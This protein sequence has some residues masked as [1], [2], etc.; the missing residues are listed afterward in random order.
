MDKFSPRLFAEFCNRVG[1]NRINAGRVAPLYLFA[2]VLHGGRV[3]MSCCDAHP[4]CTGILDSGLEAHR[5]LRDAIGLL[6]DLLTVADLEM[7]FL[8]SYGDEPF[9]SQVLY[10]NVPVFH[11]SGSESYWTIPWPS[12]YHTRALLEGS[13]D[14]TVGNTAWDDKVPKL[15]WRGTLIAPSTTLINTAH[16]YPRLRLLRLAADAPQLFDVALSGVHQTLEIQWGKKYVQQVLEQVRARFVDYEDFWTHAPLFKYVL[17]VPGVTQS[18]QLSHVLRSGSV[19]LLV[20]DPTYEHLFPLLEPWVHYVPVRADLAD[21]VPALE[22]LRRED[23]RARRIALAARA[24][25]AERLRPSATYCY[26]WRALRALRDLTEDQA[27]VA[28]AAAG[29]FTRIPEL[30]ARK[31]GARFR[32]LRERLGGT[33]L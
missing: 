27:A 20:W 14:S 9:T 17:I 24:L 13:L 2:V 25:A 5:D 16:F 23:G 3:Y 31:H 6:Q 26:L 19:P 30:D 10:S 12:V 7:Q 22:L 15:W 18:P 4:S 29:T 33:E 11:P 32:A 1:R 28:E 21:L 8:L